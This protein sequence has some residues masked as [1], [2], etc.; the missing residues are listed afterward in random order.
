MKQNKARI[1]LVCPLPPPVHGSSIVSRNIVESELL[2]SAFKVDC[3]NISTSRTMSEIG[4]FPIAKLW[5]YVGSLLRMLWLLLTRR[6]EL[7]YLA[8]TVNGIGFLKDFPFVAMARIFC[9]RRVIHQHNKGMAPYARKRIFGALLR[10]AYK[11]TKVMLLSE[12][13]YEDISDVVSHEQVLVCPNGIAPLKEEGIQ[14]NWKVQTPEPT[15]L[16]L[17]NLIESKGVWVVL[18]AC[19]ILKDKGFSFHCYFVG[20]V[21]KQIDAD[22]FAEAVRER[23]LESMVEYVG[24]KYGPDKDAYWQ[25]ADVFVFPTFYYN[26]CFPLVVLEAMQRH[27]AVVSTSEAA[28]PDIVDEGVTGLLVDSAILRQ[29]SCNEMLGKSATAEDRERSRHFNPARGQET[30][31]ALQRLL[32]DPELRRRMGEAGYEKYQREFTLEAFERRMLECLKNSIK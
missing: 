25:K 29:T 23:G 19:K 1:L 2:N 13:L 3:V 8:I 11:G 9:R 22:V 7:V 12:R 32:T 5:R 20:G 4:K 17:S 16:Y 26:E 31:Q 28:V 30:A 24:P 27:V 6:Y 18:D 14:N 10:Y 21:S 15:L